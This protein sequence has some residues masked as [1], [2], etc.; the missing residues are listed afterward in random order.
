MM[1][2]SL[3]LAT[4]AS[5]FASGAAKM[6]VG[7]Q[8]GVA[9]KFVMG[10]PEAI[11]KWYHPAGQW[12]FEYY[13]DTLRYNYTNAVQFCADRESEV[14][15]ITSEQEAEY[16]LH[17]MRNNRH[18]FWAGVVRDDTAIGV[19]GPGYGFS[20]A[21]G[22][23]IS[24]QNWAQGES[25]TKKKRAKIH[26]PNSGRN[27]KGEW[28]QSCL[29]VGFNN[30]NPTWWND[31]DC[32]LRRRVVCKRPRKECAGRGDP[33][34]CAAAIYTN[35]SSFGNGDSDTSVVNTKQQ[36][37]NA[38]LT[39]YPGC[40]PGKSKYPDGTRIY[41]CTWVVKDKC[42]IECLD[43]KNYCGTSTTT[44]APTSTTTPGPTTSTTPAP[45]TSTTPGPTT[46]TTPAK[47][48]STT[49]GETTTTTAE[50]TSTTTV[51]PTSTTTAAPTSTTTPVPYTTTSSTQLPETTTTAEPTTLYRG[52]C[53]TRGWSDE[54]PTEA[55]VSCC[56]KYVNKPRLNWHKA[57]EQC[58]ILG[59]IYDD[60]GVPSE[61]H[62]ATSWNA[63]LNEFLSDARDH[64]T[65]PSYLNQM[66]RGGSVGFTQSAWI[67]G[68]MSH[69]NTVEWANRL[70]KHKDGDYITNNSPFVD[71][72][73]CNS[74]RG[75]FGEC[76]T[77]TSTEGEVIND[78]VRN[79]MF[80]TGEPSGLSDNFGFN[81]VDESCLA[82]GSTTK[83]KTKMFGNSLWNDA[84]C[85]KKKSYMCEY[86]MATP[87]TTT[88]PQTTTT[89]E[90]PTSTTTEA[91]TSTT[92]EPPTT[93]TTEAPTSTTTE[94]PSTSTTEAPY[95]STTTTDAP[96]STTTAGP[97]STSTAAPSCSDIVCGADCGWS[98]GDNSADSNYI[99]CGW[100]SK[101]GV[102]QEGSVTKKKELAEGVCTG[103]T[104]E[105]TTA[106]LTAEEQYYA[107]GKIECS[108]ECRGTGFGEAY[109]DRKSKDPVGCGWSKK[110]GGRCLPAFTGAR[111]NFAE[112]TKEQNPEQCTDL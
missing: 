80:Y 72:L 100:S 109:P 50:P 34:Y 107:C 70:W 15:T 97:T 87:T 92:T 47:T 8:D 59:S 88:A 91:P 4:A 65:N 11:R 79:G 101:L 25:Q 58:K 105:P 78:M 24:Y 44:P 6:I 23:D 93:S 99:H 38:T 2:R 42:P 22:T 56:Y 110:N 64:R 35:F 52:P 102:C 53:G 61:G 94:P 21:D 12:Q 49:R 104:A 69:N 86:C 106:E 14:A 27:Q 5:I 57:E 10:K 31:A 95:T 13:S 112:K 26:E 84:V 30:G 55:G 54:E 75:R 108:Q 19:K 76:A 85:S 36:N 83:T 46:T 96:T 16:I 77:A 17:T 28:D 33:S 62:L 48:T 29:I 40:V 81:G 37:C 7:K 68:K 43:E 45:T 9:F 71:D 82:M 98:E 74:G 103:T 51:E 67:G 32:D 73:R 63:N 60:V 89:T 1:V 41:D 90:A 3:L 20:W 18:G 39:E 111:T 66:A